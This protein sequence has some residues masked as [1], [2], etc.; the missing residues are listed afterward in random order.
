[1]SI[2]AGPDNIETGI[3][4][5]IDAANPSSYSVEKNTLSDI[6]KTAVQPGVLTNGAT[7]VSNGVASYLN[8]AGGT[9]RQHVNFGDST[10]KVDASDKT[11]CAWIYPTSFANNPM[12]LLDKDEDKGA[13]SYGWG[14]WLNNTGKLWFWPFAAFDIID[15]GAAS[16]SLNTWNFVSMVWNRNEKTCKFYYNGVYSST[17]TTTATEQGSTSTT[18][19]IVGSIRNAITPTWHFA[20]RISHMA[21]YNRTL[22]DAEILQNFQVL[23]GRYGI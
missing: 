7:Y 3:V 2:N 1:M 16:V 18:N 17:G 4:F 5:C 9:A 15:A 10:I 20:G 21:L 12:G 23:R 6:T 11:F 8:F 19:L 14:F 13:G 22:T